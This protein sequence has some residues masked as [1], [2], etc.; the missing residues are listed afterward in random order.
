MI[1]RSQQLK[2]PGIATAEF[3]YV[4]LILFPVLIGVW[5][6]GRLIQVQQ[7]VSNSAREGARM[8]A[9]GRTINQSGAPTEI[10]TSVNPNPGNLPNVKAAVFQSLHG[11]GLTNLTWN[12]VIVTFAFL[13][14]PSGATA[15]PS[16]SNPQPV[17]GVKN[18]R[19]SVTVSIPLAKVRW[20]NFGIVSTPNVAETVEWR[21]LVDEAFTI[22]QTLPTW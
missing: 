9:Q 13:D 20:V 8:A 5:E 10:L 7:I 17:Q 21:M 2:R 15:G 4:L 1:I 11:A 16:S 14:Q 19:F 12:D 3:S 18:Q 6:T 22:N